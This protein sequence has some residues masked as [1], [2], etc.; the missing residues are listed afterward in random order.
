MIHSSEMKVFKRSA[1]LWIVALAGAGMLGC[2]TSG[3]DAG[4][5]GGASSPA[6]G[7]AAGTA[8]AG[9][10]GSSGTPGGTGGGAGTG[11][12]QGGS[13]AKGSGGNTG[14]TAASGGAAGGILGIGGSAKSGSGG[15]SAAGTTGTGGAPT[16]NAT[17]GSTVPP[18]GGSGG[19]STGG[20]AGN[21]GSAGR[22][23]TTGGGV[24]VPGCNSP[25]PAGSPVAIHGQLKVV[26]TRMQDQSGNA[27]ALKGISSYWLNWESKPDAESKAGLQSMRDNWKISILRAAMGTDVSGGYLEGGQAA[28]QAKIDTIMS[29]ALALGVYAIVDWHT[30]DAQNDQSQ[31]ITFFTG[32]ATKYGSCPNIIYED[33]N[34][35][36]N[37]TWAQIKP[38]HQAVVNAIRAIDPDN[39][40]IMGTPT[41]SQDVDLAAA[42]PVTGTNCS[43]RCT[44]TRVP[45]PRGSE[46]RATRRSPRGWRST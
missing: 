10:G 25:A 32:L 16:G 42:S 31:A 19:K 20:S 46:P 45:T 40:I 33:F 12:G 28:M 41:Y 27:V 1:I 35:P 4:G 22:G 24:T 44:G 38:Y 37:V 43:T 29:N 5:Q 2:D 21:A 26:G 23:G 39:L 7:G 30:G 9:K 36:V 34:E 6:S 14:G 11:S 8:P 18:T 3:G 15:T 13:S 17:G